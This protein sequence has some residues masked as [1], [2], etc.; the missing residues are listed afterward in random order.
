MNVDNFQQK[1]ND[2]KS[3]YNAS[4]SNLKKNFINFKLNKTNETENIYKINEKQ[5]YEIIQ[6][7]IELNTNLKSLYKENIERIKNKKHIYAELNEHL[8]E[9]SIKYNTSINLSKQ[10]NDINNYSREKNYE[11][12]VGI[13]VM[14]LFLLIVLN[15]IKHKFNMN[16]IQNI[17]STITNNIPK[18]SSSNIIN[19]SSLPK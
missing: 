13:I 7:V 15:G 2:L 16:N 11:I 18:F 14:I 9:N 19:S 3:Q 4:I 8:E 10:V 1:L 6:K 17:S 5:I 12:I